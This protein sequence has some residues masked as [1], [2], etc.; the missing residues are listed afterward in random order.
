[1]FDLFAI[2]IPLLSLILIALL[3]RKR[4]GSWSILLKKEYFPLMIVIPTLLLSFFTFLFTRQVNTS[5]LKHAQDQEKA[6]FGRRK[7]Q[8]QVTFKIDLIKISSDVD[9]D[10]WYEKTPETFTPKNITV[11]LI[12]ILINNKSKEKVPYE[13]LRKQ[14][15]T[16]TLEEEAVN[17]KNGRCRIPA[18]RKTIQKN[19]RI[20]NYVESNQL[21]HLGVG[22]EVCYNGVQGYLQP[23]RSFNFAFFP[24]GGPR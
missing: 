2:S 7:L 3:V 21:K 23:L 10:I 1:M 18:V 22:V 5:Q 8:E 14:N 11:T 24:D 4:E 6:E 16:I 19:T 12:P 9:L 15:L 13:E 20:R 17:F